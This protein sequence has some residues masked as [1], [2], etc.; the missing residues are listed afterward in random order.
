MATQPKAGPDIVGQIVLLRPEEIDATDRLRPIDPVWAE[1]LAGVMQAEGQRTPIEVCRLP[2]KTGYKLVTGGHRHAAAEMK[3]LYLRAEIV[4]NDAAERRLRE[5]SENLHRLDLAP[6]DRATFVAELVALHKVRA[7]LDPAQD[8]RAAS[9]N[10]RWQ[11]ALQ[12]EAEDTNDTMSFVYGWSDQVAEQLGFSKRTV[13][14]DL[15]LVRR[16]APSTIETLRRRNHATL[17]NASQLRAL[18][19]LTDVEQ[20]KVL[21]LLIHAD[22]KIKGAPFATVTEAIAAMADKQAPSPDAKRLNAFIGNFGRMGLAEKKGALS[23]LAGMLPAG[24]S[25]GEA[26]GQA[27]AAQLRGALS[28]AFDL[29]IKLGEGDPVEDDEIFAAHRTVQ[30]A[31]MDS[32][33]IRT[34]Q[35][36]TK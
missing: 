30:T 5:I 14:R 8:G 25:L 29:I 28:V 6:L 2:G 18:A 19:K 10:A 32:A 17:R 35:G 4:T 21:S 1:A 26:G 12:D 34:S 7:G 16:I 13:E 22:M 31:L 3:G 24:W 23:Q 36:E 20:S 33:N 15:L 9:V 27:D 11:K